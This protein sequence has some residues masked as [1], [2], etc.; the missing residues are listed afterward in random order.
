[1]HRQRRFT[2]IELL[3]VIAMIAILAGMLLPA[4]NNAR[5]RGKAA[6]CMSNLKQMALANAQYITEYNYPLLQGASGHQ[7]HIWTNCEGGFACSGTGT[8]QYWYYAYTGYMKVKLQTGQY[9]A[10]HYPSPNPAIYTCPSARR[11][12]SG[13]YMV[14]TNFGYL[15]QTYGQA[16]V[17]YT[18]NSQQTGGGSWK[19]YRISE[20][21][22][23]SKTFALAD[24]NT[25]TCNA[26]TASEVVKGTTCRIAW[27]HA[28]VSNVSWLDGHVS[29]DTFIKV[30]TK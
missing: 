22:Q 7:F 15:P 26:A 2:L 25:S 19:P 28:G 5:E 23:P 24:G 30:R 12:T 29:S 18:Y 1:M 16:L 10:Q 8:T 14:G 4:L 9:K 3:V 21:K 20:Y 17:G 13:S 27:R 11:P 6:S